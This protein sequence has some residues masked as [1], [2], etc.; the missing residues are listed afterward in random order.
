M[1]SGKEEGFSPGKELGGMEE[2]EA[3]AGRIFGG[4][5]RCACL[6]L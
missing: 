1:G 6:L 5:L 4:K 3:H 2:L